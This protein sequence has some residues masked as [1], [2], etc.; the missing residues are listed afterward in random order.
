MSRWRREH[1]DFATLIDESESRFIGEMTE[2]IATAAATNSTLPA[3]ADARATWIAARLVSTC[4]NNNALARLPPPAPTRPPRVTN[5]PSSP[6]S[7]EP[8]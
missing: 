1:P 6:A 8:G 4:R 7:G 3:L 2:C 5:C